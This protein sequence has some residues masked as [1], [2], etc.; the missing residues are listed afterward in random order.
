VTSQPVPLEEKTLN[1]QPSVLL[2][3]SH[4]LLVLSRRPFFISP[5]A[6]RHSFRS[7]LL[8]RNESLQSQKQFRSSLST[9][10][11]SRLQVLRITA[12]PSKVPRLVN[13]M[14][15]TTVPNITVVQRGNLNSLDY[16][17]YF[18]K[19]V[20]IASCCISSVLLLL[21]VVGVGNHDLL[22]LWL[23]LKR[24]VFY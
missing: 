11:S 14:S 24:H 9:L 20:F 6:L 1:M 12:T 2:H 8:I 23:R 16:R 7:L 13:N 4:R 15:T 17:L 19:E 3:Q 10:T 22:I 5:L 21:P 18:R